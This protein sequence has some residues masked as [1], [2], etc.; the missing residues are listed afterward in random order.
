M[1]TTLEEKNTALVLDALDTLFNRKDY[2]KAAQF[3]SE[4]YVQ[5][6]RHVPAGRDGLFGLVR[7]LGDVRFEYDMVVAK[8]DFVWL[9]SRYTSSATPAALIAVD[10][11]R[12]ED[13]KLVEHWDVLQDEPTRSESAGGHPMFGDTFPGER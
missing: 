5:H 10:I 2:G 1:T 7:S 6:S 9:H 11:L 3:W 13:G 8:D 12:I 4:S